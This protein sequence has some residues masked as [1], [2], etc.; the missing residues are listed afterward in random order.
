VNLDIGYT[1]LLPALLFFAEKTQSYGW[2]II[3]VTLAVRIIVWPL[4]VKSTQSMQRMAKLQPKLNQLKERYKSDP[5]MFQKKSME[6]FSKNKVNPMSGCWPVLVQMP[7]LIA[8]YAT[9][10][11][12]PFGDK[13]IDVKVNVADQ[14]LA[15]IEQAQTSSGSS[16]YVSKVDTEGGQTAP[17]ASPQGS[18]QQSLSPALPDWLKVD[19]KKAKLVVFPGDSKINVGDTIDFGIRAVEGEIPKDFAP[20]WKIILP[21]N[22]NPSDPGV[23]SADATIDQK[24]QATFNKPGEYHVQALIPGI[25]KGDRFLLISGLGKIA[26]G[27]ELLRPNNWDSLVLIILFG[28]TMYLSQKFTVAT[29]K[30]TPGQEL[31][32]QQIIQQQTMKMMPIATTGMFMFIPLPAGVLLYLVISNVFQTLQTLLIMKMPT[33]AFIDVTGDDGDT[34]SPQP[35]GNQPNKPNGPKAPNSA[36]NVST[37]SGARASRGKRKAKRKKN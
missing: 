15:K 2:A 11:G 7:I 33:P 14:H 24:G 22:K 23:V 30:P 19:S 10:T 13:V 35:G 17:V 21:A 3:L 31:D 28:A 32:E 37:I 8:L 5:E 36:G 9:F 18:P 4:V 16:P 27:V 26:R 25:A 1:F 29:Q 34:G 12:P 6:F 20:T